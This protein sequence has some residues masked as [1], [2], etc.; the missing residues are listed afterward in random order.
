[1]THSAAIPQRTGERSRFLARRWNSDIVEGGA[2]AR[3]LF[4]DSPIPA[5]GVDDEGRIV[6]AND[7]MLRLLGY[8]RA[9]YLGRHIDQV[10]R[11]HDETDEGALLADVRA[12]ARQHYEIRKQLKRA[13]GSLVA[14]R[15]VVG[16]ARDSAGGFVGVV[17]QFID[18]STARLLEEEM[19]RSRLFHGVTGLPNWELFIERV[20]L[21]LHAASESGCSVGV[22]D[23]DLDRFMHVNDELGNDSG[24]ALMI[25]TGQR[26]AQ[27]LNRTDTL[28]HLSGDEFVVVRPDLRDHSALADFGRELVDIFDEP[29]VIEGRE[30]RLSA[31]IGLSTG[32]EDATSER[33]IRDSQLARERA[34][35]HGGGRFV[36]FEGSLRTSALITDSS[37]NCLVHAY[38]ADQL[39]VHYQP[40]IALE[41]N[42][43]VGVE[44]LLRWNDPAGGARLPSE[45]IRAAEETELIVPIGAMVLRTA[46]EQAATW[47]C[48]RESA[49]RAWVNVSPVQLEDQGFLNL[50]GEVLTVSGLP[51]ENLTLELT[52]SALMENDPQVRRTLKALRG[53]GVRIAID[54]FGTGYSS[55]GRIRRL[56]VDELKIDREFISEMDSDES[57]RQIVLAIIELGKALSATIVAEGVETEAIADLLRQLGC[58]FAQGYLFGRPGAPEERLP[59]IAS[60]G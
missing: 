8:E 34:R 53:L 15:F 44:A 46:C 49:P 33:L 28:G 57:A 7:A 2:L 48:G 58:P 4:D 30:I 3:L 52:E 31:S 51:A 25:A 9:K 35:S 55:L 1:M 16:A 17:A 47:G 24:N 32:G 5:Q 54:D 6:V 11:P 21:A 22:A 26:M 37:R 56:P 40:L 29:F 50:V 60:W 18:E 38:E 36:I 27:R 59:L 12:G 20:E 23:V 41:T 45:F 14:G 19:R 39:T 13:D 10:A 42:E 43:C